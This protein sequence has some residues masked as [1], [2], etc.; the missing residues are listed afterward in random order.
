MPAGRV[1]A[2]LSDH[3]GWRSMSL[4]SGRFVGSKNL[5]GGRASACTSPHSWSGNLV[6]CVAAVQVEQNTGV[7]RCIATDEVEMLW[8]GCFSAGFHGDLR[9]AHVDCFM[10]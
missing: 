6:T 5:A 9:A 3:G 4:L 8:R 2:C 10:S 1:L 7:G